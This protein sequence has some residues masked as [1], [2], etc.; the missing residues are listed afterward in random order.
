MKRKWKFYLGLILILGFLG[1]FLVYPIFYI[2]K[3]S[4]WV[5]EQGRA[6]FTIIFFQL[7]SQSPVMWK[8]LFNSFALAILTTLLCSVIALP[9]A[10]LFVRYDFPLKTLWQAL[11]MGPL[12]L[13]PFVGAIG[14]QQ[15]LGRFGA[16]NHLLGLVGPNV[17]HPHPI[18]WLGSGGFFG[19]VM[20]QSLHLFPIL[21]LNLSASLANINPAVREA[22]RCLG[23][24]QGHVFRT[25]TLPLMM[26]GF[27]AGAVIVFIW[28]F[29][30]LGT[31][32]IFG[33]YNVVAVQ[34]FDKVTETGFNPFGH[35]LVIVVLIV[36]MVTF[37]WS[38]RWV[39]RQ[40]FATQGK[41][42]VRE[43][44]MPLHGMKRLV[45]T[46][47][48]MFICLLALLP[49][50]SVILQSLSG[51]WFMSTLPREWTAGHYREIFTLPQTVTGL[52]NSLL[53]S[54]LSA[55]LDV[56]LGVVIAYWLARKEFF[57][58]AILDSL[59]V[60]PLAVPG[61]VLA[62]G[63]VAAFNVPS[64]WHGMDLTWLRGFV[65]SRENPMFLLVIS[66]SVRRLPYMVRAAHAGLQ[67]MSVSLEEASSNL[68]A[69]S[70]TTVRRIVLPLLKGNILAGAILTFAFAFLEVSDSLILA[71][72]EEFY[73]VTK[74][75]WALMGRIEPGAD[76]VASALGALGMLLLFA[77]IY[78]SNRLLGKKMGSLFG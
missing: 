22:A 46:L 67:Q 57:G 66:Y 59:T 73:P 27:F 37:L 44:W 32:L 33:F 26:P 75:I 23:A 72:K 62:F 43:E 10:H 2:M 9:L 5:E 31:P 48:I 17:D 20:M 35:T 7:F 78:T 70:F 58:K 18:D 63:Y 29:T 4:V 13:P 56:I 11:L 69:S 71:I 3:E 30:D 50:A 47:G 64:T 12:I 60:L 76:S 49:H 41:A 74:T 24:T 14:I 19:I 54:S 42:D 39:A 61:I 55:G 25:I 68:G 40:D 16:L 77:A 52:K 1:V 36:T 34:I 21:F 6:H 65:N 38:R 45:V 28:A 51:K 8:C 53:Y 15:L